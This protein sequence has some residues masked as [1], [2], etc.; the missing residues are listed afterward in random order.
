MSH[1]YSFLGALDRAIQAEAQAT[2][3]MDDLDVKEEYERISE[4]VA[5]WLVIEATPPKLSLSEA[6]RHWDDIN[7]R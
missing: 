7:H 4:R 3:R 6:K 5:R 1:C 2:A